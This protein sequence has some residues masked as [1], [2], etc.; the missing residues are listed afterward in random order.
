MALR[1]LNHT[2]CVSKHCGIFPFSFQFSTLFAFTGKQ[3]FIL[4]KESWRPSQ[5]GEGGDKKQRSALIYQVQSG[6]NN[7]LLSV[8]KW[9]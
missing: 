9:L 4:K 6:M 8:I 2:G 1:V 3:G 5:A 7:L